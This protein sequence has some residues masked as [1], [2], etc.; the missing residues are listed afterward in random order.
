MQAACLFKGRIF[1][2]ESHVR[3]PLMNSYDF[4]EQTAVITGGCNGIELR[5][6]KS[7]FILVQE[8]V[9]GT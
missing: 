8:S 1:Q 7:S 4:S 5:L 2:L 9:F 6:S 3:R